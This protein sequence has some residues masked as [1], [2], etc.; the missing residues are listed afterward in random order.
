MAKKKKTTSKASGK[1]TLKGSKNVGKTKLM[2]CD[3]SVHF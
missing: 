2:F 3:G 1:K